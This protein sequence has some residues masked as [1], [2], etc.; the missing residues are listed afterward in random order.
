MK[1]STRYLV[2][3]VI[4]LLGLS[5]PTILLAQDEITLESLARKVET[6]FTGQDDLKARMAAVE[7]QIAPTQTKARPSATITPDAA[8]TKKARA[9]LAQEKAT[10]TPRPTL[11]PTFTPEPE[12]LLRVGVEDFFR[13]YSMYKGMT[14]EVSG[15][16]EKKKNDRVELHV[17]GWFS[18]FVCWLSPDEK[19]LPLVLKNRQSVILRGNDVYK[20]SNT[21]YMRNC[22]F[23]S[24][25]PAELTH[26][27]GTR[28][29]T[30]ATAQSVEATATIKAQKTRRA[31]RAT[32]EAARSTRRAATATARAKATKRAE[33]TP[34]P[35]A[36]QSGEKTYRAEISRIV[37]EDPLGYDVAN[38]L[39]ILGDAFTRAGDNPFLFMNDQWKIEVALAI[40]SLSMSYDE[41]RKLKPPSNLKAFHNLVIEGLSYCD[42]AGDQMVEG[43]DELDADALEDSVG[44]IE[45]CGALLERAAADPNW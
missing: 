19:N 25:T 7:T 1:G 3:I 2:G 8:A 42:L 20:E 24:P 33:G 18:Y 6:L 17:P 13:E 31:E 4:V 34:T 12:S 30:T 43:I 14:I 40:G 28:V 15:E 44:L 36:H 27:Y 23:V 45:L 38:A 39:S 21:V 37:F 26:L 35:I 5:L 22:S 41:A 9:A 10:A 11:G 32:Q 16:V 29:A